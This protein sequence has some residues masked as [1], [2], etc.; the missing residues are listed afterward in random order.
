MQPDPRDLGYLFDMLEHARGV[1]RSVEH[2]TLEAYL[3]DQDLRLAV[4]RRIEIIGEAA[5]KVSRE[6]RAAHPE[7]PWRKVIAQRN[8]LIH[9]YGE[10]ED[11]IVWQ[12]ATNSI[13]ELI[14]LIE[15]LVPFPDD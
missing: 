9:E 6:F 12:V 10:I 11:E 15:P 4:E 3:Q 7:I 8:V 5:R 14:D 1:L 2:K 13:P